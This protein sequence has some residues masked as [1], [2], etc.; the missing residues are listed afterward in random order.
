MGAC[1]EPT[2]AMAPWYN[3]EIRRESAYLTATTYIDA[4]YTMRYHGE[5]ELTDEH[6]AAAWHLL[7]DHTLLAPGTPEALTAALRQIT[8]HG[9][10][11]E[12][13]TGGSHTGGAG[14]ELRDG[15]L[16]V[17][18]PNSLW[19]GEE[20]AA[21]ISHVEI[22]YEDVAPVLADLTSLAAR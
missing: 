11:Q 9:A 17:T 6:R 12:W 2:P 14:A 1:L 21:E 7:D 18:L 13:L 15:R 8:G 10:Y 16:V 3:V 19:Y 20:G 5:G 4:W 22:G